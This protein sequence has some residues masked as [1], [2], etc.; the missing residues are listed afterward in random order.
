MGEKKDRRP[1]DGEKKRH[2]R[3][4][5]RTNNRSAL[6]PCEPPKGG[7]PLNTPMVTGVQFKV[8]ENQKV[9]GKN[10]QQ[11]MEGGNQGRWD[12]RQA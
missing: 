7:C 2:W 5:E 4:K 3:R 1:L 11:E 6:K 12:K 9:K 10:R 8:E